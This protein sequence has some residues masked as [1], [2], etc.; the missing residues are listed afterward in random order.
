ME[1]ILE[2][3]LTEERRRKASAKKTRHEVTTTDSTDRMDI[4]DGDPHRELETAKHGKTQCDKTTT[5]RQV[6]QREGVTEATSL[7]VQK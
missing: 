4:D 7:P 2:Y 5:S 6:S 1:K 3:V